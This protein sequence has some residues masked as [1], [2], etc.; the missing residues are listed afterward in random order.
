MLTSISPRAWLLLYPPDFELVRLGEGLED[1]RFSISERQRLK[2]IRHKDT[3]N[4][5]ALAR[6]LARAVLS[7]EYGRSSEKWQIGYNEKGRPRLQNCPTEVPDISIS[8]TAGM[9][10]FAISPKGLIGVDVENCNRRVDIHLLAREVFSS[11]ESLYFNNLSSA[12]DRKKYFFQN[13]TLKE[14]YTKALGLG[15][16]AGFRSIEI[17]SFG[18]EIF[19]QSPAK[20]D[21]YSVG[22]WCFNHQVILGAFHVAVAHWSEISPSMSMTWKIHPTSFSIGD[23]NL[24]GFHVSSSST[25]V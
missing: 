2:S 8:H 10:A 23:H 13:W 22:S 12:L 9:V 16:Y 1:F 3:R 24:E 11:S 21:P 6:S 20:D 14:A 15:L 19:L 17:N 18:Q 5:F 4:Q 25:I 7:E